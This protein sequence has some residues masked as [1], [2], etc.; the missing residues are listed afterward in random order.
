MK[1]PAYS[2]LTAFLA[3]YRALGKNTENEEER[4]TLEE[5]K[6]LF[7]L[8]QPAERAALLD[9]AANGLPGTVEVSDSALNA[10]RPA[11]RAGPKARL[12]E[13]AERRLRQLLVAKGV[14]GE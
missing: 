13:R 12:R 9:Q 7:E 11:D 6:R 10:L 8:L 14:L 2:S 3:H 4:A 5:M 1:L